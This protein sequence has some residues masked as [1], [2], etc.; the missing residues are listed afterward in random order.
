MSLIPDDTPERLT[1]AVL[2][3]FRLRACDGQ[4][5]PNLVREGLPTTRSRTIRVIRDCGVSR[6]RH[7]LDKNDFQTREFAGGKV[8]VLCNHRSRKQKVERR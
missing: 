7:S 5:F 3:G 4:L 1:R 2:M 6:E 8:R